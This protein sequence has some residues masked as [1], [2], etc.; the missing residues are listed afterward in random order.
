MKKKALFVYG[1]PIPQDDKKKFDENCKKDIKLMS[2]IAEA[3]GYNIEQ[4]GIS[5]FDLE[6][7]NYENSESF[8]FYFTGHANNYVFGDGFKSL[9]SLFY[10]IKKING[11]KIVVLDACTG[12]FMNKL[13]LPKDTTLFGASKIYPALSLAKLLYEAV[14]YRRKNLEEINKSVFDEMK[15]NWVYFKK[16]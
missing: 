1:N 8:L 6:M 5:E 11:K 3:S 16:N 15:Q 4:K 14:I 9:N 2:E 13:N 7:K 12:E 10:S